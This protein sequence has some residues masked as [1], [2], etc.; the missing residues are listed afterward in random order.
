MQLQSPIKGRSFNVRHSWCSPISH[1]MEVVKD[2]ESLRGRQ[3]EIVV[4]QVSL[5][6]E[7]LSAS[8]RFQP[9]YY[10][11]PHGSVE[12]GLNWDDGHIA[13]HKLAAVL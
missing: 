13:Y 11:A 12:N 2:F 1:V 6:G 8:F 3:N 4:K 10:I 7:G 9:P 5:A